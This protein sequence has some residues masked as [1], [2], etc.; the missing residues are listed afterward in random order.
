M[1]FLLR[2]CF[3]GYNKYNAFSPQARLSKSGVK[4]FQQ[5][6]RGENTMLTLTHS[7]DEEED[8]EQVAREYLGRSI[9]VSW[10][11]MIEA[12]VLAVA[13]GCVK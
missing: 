10:P 4:V 1:K 9:Y 2:G 11:H 12:R 13:D 3:P 6:S 8:V 5:N 7:E